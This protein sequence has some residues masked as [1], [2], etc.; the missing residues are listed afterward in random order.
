MNETPLRLLEM[1]TQT[2]EDLWR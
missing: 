1:L 2:R